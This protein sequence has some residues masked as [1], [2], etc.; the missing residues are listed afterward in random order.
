MTNGRLTEEP[1][2]VKKGDHLKAQDISQSPMGA[3]FP[4]TRPEAEAVFI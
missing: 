3:L 2:P 1:F 4:D